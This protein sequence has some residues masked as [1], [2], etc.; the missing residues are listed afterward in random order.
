MSMAN[1]VGKTAFL[2]MDPYEV[3]KF[4]Y[5]LGLDGPNA[6]HNYSFVDKYYNDDLSIDLGTDF[7]LVNR[8]VERISDMGN[9]REDFNAWCHAQGSCTA[10]DA[11]R[12]SYHMRAFT[13][14]PGMGTDEA[15]GEFALENN[16]FED[17]NALP[18]DI[19]EALDK[20][21]A[22]ARMREME[23]GVFVDG[24][25]LVVLENFSQ[26]PLPA[27]EPLAYFQVRFSDTQ[28]DS[29]WCD[30]PLSA[31][32]DSRIAVMLE[33]DRGLEMECR[34]ILPQLNGIISG[35]DE[36]PELCLLSTAL[37]GMSG[38]DIQKYK[39]LLEVVGPG[40]PSTAL[41][42]A[43]EIGHYDVTLEYADPANYGLQ[44][45]AYTY[46]LEADCRLLDYVDLAGYG[47]EML[48]TEGYEATRYGAVYRN[49]MA[50]KF[51]AGPNTVYSGDYYCGRTEGFPTCV[52]W[53]P[54]AQKIWL[55]LNDGAASSE[56]VADMAYYRGICEDWGVRDCV[57]AN[58]Y[59]LYLSELGAQPYDEIMINDQ[60][61]GGMGGMA[62]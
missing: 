2:P 51:L 21:K 57:S 23:G 59:D 3:E 8:L 33:Q 26:E 19:Y 18:P 46:S 30:V 15:L 39:A 49:V 47:S 25:Y 60:G 4:L 5:D 40:T 62:G 54:D 61:M 45:A 48:R 27:E 16:Y 10:E 37:N 55:E 44:H 14:F 29:G 56:M 17:Y 42:L 58:E 50:M 35:G 52:C 7:R 6:E 41:R 38:D 12:A 20:T 1:I 53:D 32:D 13:F 36:L 28:H 22:G 11:L 43:Y 24:G 34:S 31:G 9:R